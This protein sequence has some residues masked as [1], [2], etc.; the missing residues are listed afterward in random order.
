MSKLLRYS[1]LTKKFIMS[2]AG[3][4]LMLFLIVHVGINLFI[5]PVTENHREIFHE[6]VTFMTT[7]PLIK[8]MEIFLFS[9]FIIHILYGVILQIQNWIARG[10]F[11][12][13]PNWSNTSFFS[14]FMI[15]TGI[16]VLIF[17][18]IHLMNFYLVKMGVTG[19][20][21]GVTPLEGSHDFYG[22][23][24]NLFSNPYY[25]VGY[26]VMMIIL[27]FH[28]IHSF[29]SAFQSLGIHHPVYTPVIKGVGYLY[30]IAIPLGFIIIPLYFLLY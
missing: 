18:V 30:A 16:L 19:P 11:Y 14:K 24:V 10:K 15:H 27:A 7:N 13:K 3:I 12:K 28:L 8:V 20:P 25:S 9:A 1:S 17:L 26:I 2:L 6:A 4:F 23:A 29:Q 21:E 5:I 22:M